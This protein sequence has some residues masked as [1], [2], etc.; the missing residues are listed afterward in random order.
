V[1]RRLILH[2]GTHRTATTA[3]QAYLHDNFRPLKT[4]GFLYPFKVR[5]HLKLM[6]QLFSGMR[7]L[8]ETAT[9]I[10]KRADSHR[11]DLHTVILSD[12]D[13]CQREDLRLLGRFRDTF[14]VKVVFTLRRQDIWLESWFLQNV[15]WQWNKKL[16]HCSLDEFLAMRED[17]H[18]IHYD[19]Y[20][21]HLEE[22]FGRENIILNIHEKQQMLGGSIETF[23]NSIGLTN[24]DG[25]TP[26]EHINESFS[27]EISE[28]M[29]CLPLGQAQPEYRNILVSACAGIDHNLNSTGKKQSERIISHAERLAL[30]QA[31]Q[32]GNRALAQ[33]YFKRDQL[34]FDPLPD[35]DAPLAD[36]TLPDDSYQL[37]E[38]FVAPLVKAL[39]L[40][41]K[42]LS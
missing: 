11:E 25:L 1:K 22:V 6:N 3:L 33:R 18:W 17:F 35:P 36:M 32:D 16:S 19:R 30:M 9:A 31:Y 13:I 29:R 20:V 12:E 40:E 42:K 24:R 10:A 41:R 27:P 38:Q 34:F 37:M 5:R 39:I 7:D 15:K 21:R 14:D 28:F 2:I 23:A 8:Q 4:K 26:P